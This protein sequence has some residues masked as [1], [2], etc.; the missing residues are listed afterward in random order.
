MSRKFDAIDVVKM[1]STFSFLAWRTNL[2]HAVANQQTNK[3][4]GWR[5]GMQAG[6]AKAN[7]RN[8][9]S[10]KINIWTV[11]RIRDI[12][13]AMKVILRKRHPMAMDN[14]KADPLLKIHKH[15]EAKRKRDAE[16]EAFLHK[17]SF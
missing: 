12:E 7:D 6:L 17:S 3:L 11:Q 13:K 14:S 10:D 16:F 1:Y 2:R 9:S 15:R 4:V 8:V 5:Y